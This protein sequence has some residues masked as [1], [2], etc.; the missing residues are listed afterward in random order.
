[1]CITHRAFGGVSGVS[2]VY[3]C[4]RWVGCTGRSVVVN[5]GIVVLCA[6]CVFCMAT[7]AITVIVIGAGSRGNGYSTYSFD[8]P[9]RLAIV[10]IAEV[11]EDRRSAFQSKYS[12]SE[13]M[14]FSSWQDLA[15]TGKKLSDAV[16]ITTLDQMHKEPAIAMAKLGYSIL[17]E[18]PMAVSEQDCRDIVDV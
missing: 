5:S 17:L 8:K 12:I 11:E 2:G 1:M 13:E 14:V 3:R 9:D 18:K 16:F 4:I 6:N 7:T 10:G 15:A